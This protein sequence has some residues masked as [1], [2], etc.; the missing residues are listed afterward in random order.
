[1]SAVQVTR[2]VPAAQGTREVLVVQETREVRA[3]QG[4]KGRQRFRAPRRIGLRSL[5]NRFF[6]GELLWGCEWEWSGLMGWNGLWNGFMGMEPSL[7]SGQGLEPTCV[8][9]SVTKITRVI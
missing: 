5:A 4:T 6:L 1:M 3:A 9:P 7:D 2:E 8:W